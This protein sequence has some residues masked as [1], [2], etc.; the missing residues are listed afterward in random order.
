MKVL[1][2]GSTGGTGRATVR[3]LLAE[4]HEVTAFGRNPEP[5]F[6]ATPR[7]TLAR[8]D[9]TDAAAVDRAVKDHDAV[10]V[11]LGISENPI[12]VRLSGPARTPL[13]VRSRGTRLV[14]EAM[15]RHG[16]RRLVVLTSYGVGATRARLTLADR[17]FFAVLLAP[18]IADTELQET[19]VRDSDLDW[20]L[21]QP[22]HLTDDADDTP[23]YVAFDGAT[24]ARSVS[25][26]SVARALADAVT[27]SDAVHRTLAVSATPAPKS[28]TVVP[29]AVGDA[30]TRR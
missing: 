28:S 22:V 1:V 7:L 8:G 10:V 6:E 30:D 18:Q 11:A 12:R 4:G 17:L 21:V 9:A 5:V 29:G 27:R 23:P 3:R 24:A 2:L 14:V 25:R 16:A 19:I 26:A 13:D 20:V 15:R